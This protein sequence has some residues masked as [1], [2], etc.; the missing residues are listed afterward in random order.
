MEGKAA[1]RMTLMKSV[2]MVLTVVACAWAAAD[3]GA[4]AEANTGLGLAREGKY[5][6]AIPHYRAAIALDAH[7]PGIYLNLGL[8]YMKLNKFPDA[9]TAL[10][11]AVQADPS[12]FQPRV[13]WA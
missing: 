6:L 7:L 9:A 13:F 3:G 5:E 12:G 2:A 10:E 1:A 4:L 11:G 8:A